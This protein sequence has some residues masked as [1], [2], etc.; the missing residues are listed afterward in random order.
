MS[1]TK[2]GD[3]FSAHFLSSTFLRS[4]YPSVSFY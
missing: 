2:A 1:N 4:R 3:R